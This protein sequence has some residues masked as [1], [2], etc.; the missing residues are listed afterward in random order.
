MDARVARYPE[1]IDLRLVARNALIGEAEAITLVANHVSAD[2]ERAAK[3]LHSVKGRVI[4][5]G[6]GKSGHIA[7]KIASTFSSIGKPAQ[8]IH[9]SEASHGDLGALT[10]SDIV[11]ALSNSGETAELSDFVAFC[12][13]SHI[14]IVAITGNGESSL[15][16][17]ATLAIVYPPVR[18][19][20]ALGRAPTTSTT[21][22]MAIGD[23][24]A[25]LLT[26]LIG[27]TDE[28]FGRRH[29]GGTLGAR[30]LRIHELMHVGDRLP[31]VDATASMHE[32]VIEM[33]QKGFG[34]TIVRNAQGEP[35]GIITDGDLRRLGPS[36]WT[37]KAGEVAN[38]KPFR[39][40]Q[41]ELVETALLKMHERGVTCLL[42][43]DD[44]DKVIGL[45]H[46]HD[47][48]RGSL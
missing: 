39:V 17:H 15:A 31:I 3:L 9:A 45:V 5:T 44:T 11:V 46:I 40:D 7:G 48:L 13:E 25:V 42:A 30:L 14:P 23:A 21:V 35:A 27:T 43:T 26:H 18:E 24:V 36:L 47:C 37:L 38:Y 1:T 20:C 2:I 10:S 34:T 22:M 28:H 12:I 33:S 41:K 16:R 32:V 19:V 8:F 4:V 29:P 6:I